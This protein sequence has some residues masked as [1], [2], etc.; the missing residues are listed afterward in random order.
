V[1]TLGSKDTEVLNTAIRNGGWRVVREPITEQIVGG[2]A[3]VENGVIQSIDWVSGH[4]PGNEVLLAEARAAFALVS[5][6]L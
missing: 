2:V 4:F 6:W 3:K 5:S 1:S